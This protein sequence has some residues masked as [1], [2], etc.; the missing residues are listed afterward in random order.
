MRVE[1]EVDV[2]RLVGDH[3]NV[4]ALKA[5][6][7]DEQNLHLLLQLCSKGD[8]ATHIVSEG[9]LS[10]SKARHYFRHILQAVVHCHKHGRMP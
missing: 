8:L 6:Y 1:Q 3:E 4:T 5:V 7:E 9:S 2:L 10:E